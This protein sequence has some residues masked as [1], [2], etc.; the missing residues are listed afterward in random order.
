MA[1]SR[2]VYDALTTL[3]LTRVQGGGVLS[4]TIEGKSYVFDSL[5]AL[6]RVRAKLAQEV[7]TEQ[8]TSIYLAQFAGEY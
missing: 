4:F 1:T 8:E 5:D 6:M 2:E 3:L 7:M